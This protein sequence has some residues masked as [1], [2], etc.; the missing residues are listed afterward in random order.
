MDCQTKNYVPLKPAGLLQ[1][2]KVGGLF[3]RVGIDLVGPFKKSN[4]GKRY[5]IVATDY[6]TRYVE[7]RA[8]ATMNAEEVAEFIVD[9][10]ILRHGSA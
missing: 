4:E 7:T 9:E 5:I 10:I 6:L 1:P 2:I 3:E 8:L